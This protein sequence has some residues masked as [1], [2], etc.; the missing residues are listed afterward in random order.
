[1]ARW[2]PCLFGLLIAALV[3]SGPLL[4]RSWRAAESRNFREVR[5]GVLYRSGQ[6]TLSGIKEAIHA[7]GIKTV[8]S[9]RDAHHPGDPPP[10]REEEQYCRKIGLTYERLSPVPWSSA[11]GSA[12]RTM[13]TVSP[14]RAMLTTRASCKHTLASS[15]RRTAW[16]KN[17]ST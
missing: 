15:K 3:V 1:M 16:G 7:H 8:V 14:S 13:T 5:E 11:D 6:M 2:F 10:D 9:L 12:R 17:S 4:Y